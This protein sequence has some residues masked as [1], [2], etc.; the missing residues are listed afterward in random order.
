M[1]DVRKIARFDNG[2][3]IEFTRDLCRRG[4]HETASFD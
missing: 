1:I 2:R 4:T 3:K